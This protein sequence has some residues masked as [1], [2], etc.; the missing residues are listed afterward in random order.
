MN[1]TEELLS[2]WR[3]GLAWRSETEIKS[4]IDQAISTTFAWMAWLLF[5]AFGLAYG[6]S[7]WIVPIPLHWTAIMISAFGW[8]GL[9]FWI[10]YRRQNMSYQTLAA[11]LI[12]FAVLEWYWLAWIF[13]WYG[14]W[15][16]YQAF[17]S[18]TIMF[19]VLAFAWY[20]LKIDVARVGN[21]LMIWLVALIIA[22]V[23]NFFIANAAF[24]IRISVIWLV[25]FA[26][27]I[28][29]D[30]NVLKQQALVDDERIPLLMSLGLFINFINIFLFLLRLM[31]GRD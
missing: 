16:V 21:I 9:V 6:I 13:L 27:F 5:I 10:S 2:K 25:I 20:Y 11:L 28:I 3:I 31:W 8:L 15:A 30:M 18:A 19:A 1:F 12:G 24:D 23:A 22:M 17:L 29:Y 14:L 7:T 4:K 26:W